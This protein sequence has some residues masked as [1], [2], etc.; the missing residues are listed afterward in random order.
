MKI[1]IHP[2]KSV[3]ASRSI[4]PGRR[5]YA[6][7]DAD[8]ATEDDELADGEGV[9]DEDEDEGTGDSPNVEKTFNE[10][11]KKLRKASYAELGDALEDIVSD[12]KLY[13]ILSEGFG[14]GELAKVTMSSEPEAIPVAKLLPTQSEIGLD[15]SLKFPLSNDCSQL[16]NG[17]PV[18]IVTPIVTYNGQYVIDGHHRWSQLY[19]MNP[20]AKINAINFE[21]EDQSP[22]RALRNFQGAV[23][24]ANKKVPK[25]YSKVNNVY[26]MS[27]EE[28]ENYLDKNISDECWGSLVDVGVCE[29]RDSAIEYIMDNI[30][31]LQDENFPFSPKAPKREYMPQTNEKA[32]DIAE[33]GQTNI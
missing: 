9:S 7:D 28:I 8:N 22:F 5:I 13:A 27:D 26:D 4:R 17:S 25:S 29:D 21:Y 19:M 31:R 33:E 1:L 3:R 32:I 6:S 2:R 15:N 23:A 30:A 11:V 24:I 12:P 14:E 18:T 10:L 16:F 20:D